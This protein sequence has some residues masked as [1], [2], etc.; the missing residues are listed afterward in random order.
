MKEE[1]KDEESEKS[2]KSEESEKSEMGELNERHSLEWDD[3]VLQA[4]FAELHRIKSMSGK[5]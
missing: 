1:V 5:Y 4:G 2:V 3:C